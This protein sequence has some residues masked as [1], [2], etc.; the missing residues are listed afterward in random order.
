MEADVTGDDRRVEDPERRPLVDAHSPGVRDQPG[1]DPGGTGC[2]DRVDHR[3][4]GR[5]AAEEP[6]DQLGRIDAEHLAEVTLEL[7]AGDGAALERAEQ[8]KGLAVAAEQLEHRAALE[9]LVLAEAI[10]AVPDVRG[11]D[12]AEIDQEPLAVLVPP[13]WTHI[14]PA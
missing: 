10:E 3:L 11:Q 7:L 6:L 1:P 8:G 12:A 13:W 5:E 4:L 9:A 2:R 14:S